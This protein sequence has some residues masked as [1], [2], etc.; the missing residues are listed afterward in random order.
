MKQKLWREG[1]TLQVGPRDGL[2]TWL[3]LQG[4]SSYPSK[5]MTSQ[6]SVLNP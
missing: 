6:D 3:C 2:D 5:T 1:H 4:I